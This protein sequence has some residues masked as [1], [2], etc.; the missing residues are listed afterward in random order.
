[1]IGL[2]LSQIVQER[3]KFLQKCSSWILMVNLD[4]QESAGLFMSLSSINS[5]YNLT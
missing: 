5:L 3:G 2:K 4:G 1:M